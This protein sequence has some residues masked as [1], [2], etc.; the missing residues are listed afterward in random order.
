MMNLSSVRAFVEKNH[1]LTL[2]LYRQGYL[3]SGEVKLVEEAVPGIFCDK[4]GLP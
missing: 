3:S 2:E 1:E 4:V